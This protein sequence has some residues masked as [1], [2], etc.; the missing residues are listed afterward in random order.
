MAD[1]RQVMVA[2]SGFGAGINYA[3]LQ[4]VISEG[5]PNLK[6]VNK[7]Y[8]QIG[9]AGRDGKEARIELI[10]QHIDVPQL[11]PKQ[12]HKDM[13][14]FKRALMNLLNFV[15]TLQ[16]S[17]TAANQS[18]SAVILG[19]ITKRRLNELLARRHR[20][21]TKW[22]QHYREEFELDCIRTAC[23]RQETMISG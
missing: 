11:D 16:V 10:P 9:R 21:W 19:S 2:T 20:K 23:K 5:I 1:A 7:I 12:D 8:Q 6:E 3:H 17:A 13:E 18:S 22:H 15:K 4:L 14:D